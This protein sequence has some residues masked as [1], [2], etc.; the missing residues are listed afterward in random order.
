MNNLPPEKVKKTVEALELTQTLLTELKEDIDS[1]FALC[2]E[3]GT[4]TDAIKNTK[5][6]IVYLVRTNSDTLEA[7]RA[8]QF[9]DMSSYDPHKLFRSTQE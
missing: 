1:Y 6:E 9:V 5:D 3:V 2:E 4:T 7:V 8:L